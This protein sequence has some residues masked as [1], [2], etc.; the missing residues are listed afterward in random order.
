MT[1]GS[2]GL[3]VTVVLSY[4]LLVHPTRSS[5]LYIYFAFIR[6]PPEDDENDGVVVVVSSR[7]N[8]MAGDDKTEVV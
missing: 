2:I 6:P 3:I 4:P 1:A 7:K 5:L 8:S